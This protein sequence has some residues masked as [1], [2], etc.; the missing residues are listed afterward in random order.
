MTLPINLRPRVQMIANADTPASSLPY[1]NL[2]VVLV[3]ADMASLGS[4]PDNPGQLL[5][6]WGYPTGT[7]IIDGVTVTQYLMT[8][9]LD[10]VTRDFIRDIPGVT[11]WKDIN[12]RA[13]Y[14][15][16]ARQL[17]RDWSV[18]A[19]EVRT[20]LQALFDAAKIEVLTP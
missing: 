6:V 7:V 20:Y 13:V 10:D 1:A 2:V 12:Q 3:D 8:N 9:A 11:G 4:G 17:I 14:R 5:G 19:P 16:T 18:P 15:Q